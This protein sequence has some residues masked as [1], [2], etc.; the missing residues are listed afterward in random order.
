[1]NNE[2]LIVEERSRDIGKFLVRRL[3]PFRKKASRPIYFH[4]EITWDQSHSQK[5]MRST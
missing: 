2:K 4:T 3:L 1:M 5:V